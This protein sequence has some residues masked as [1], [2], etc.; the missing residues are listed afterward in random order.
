MNEASRCLGK[1]TT[2]RDMNVHRRAIDIVQ[3]RT[4]NIKRFVDIKK[5]YEHGDYTGGKYVANFS[6]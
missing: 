5:L 4:E 2:P 1:V 3:I 6:L